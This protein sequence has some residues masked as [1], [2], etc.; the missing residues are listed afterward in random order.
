MGSDAGAVELR[1]ACAAD[2]GQIHAVVAA[3]YE[4]YRA[5]MDRRPAPLTADYEALVASGCVTV[6][7]RA[8]EVLGVLVTVPH[9]DHL[10]VDNVAVDPAAQGTGVGRRL[11]ECAEGQARDLG[12]DELRLYTN[13]AMTENLEYYPRRGYRETGRRLDEGFERVFFSRRLR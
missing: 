12:L 5:R 7:V 9:P 1:R 13:A 2:V 8:G 6:A 10:H 4:P 3:A 11:L